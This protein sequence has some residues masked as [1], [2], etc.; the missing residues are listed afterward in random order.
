MKI[1]VHIERLILDGL[2]VERRDAAAVQ[3]AV[4]AE[5]TRLIGTEGLAQNL[6]SGSAMPVARGG[7]I[8]LTSESD[9]THLGTQI[10][11]AVH[12]GLVNE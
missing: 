9:P 3:A 10:A 2:P 5:L 6:M 7:A 8:Q 1:A 4:Q 12:R 11:Q